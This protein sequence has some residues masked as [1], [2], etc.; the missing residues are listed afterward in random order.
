M[1]FH[2]GGCGGDG[3]ARC[4]LGFY[5]AIEFALLEAM[6][7]VNTDFSV[8]IRDIIREGLLILFQL[9]RCLAPLLRIRIVGKHLKMGIRNCHGAVALFYLGDGEDTACGN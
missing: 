8:G 5:Q 1:E 6:G 4:R 7:R 9:H 3:V 2:A